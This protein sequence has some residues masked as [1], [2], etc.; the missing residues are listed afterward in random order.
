MVI[1]LLTDSNRPCRV[2]YHGDLPVPQPSRT[3]DGRGQCRGLA[4]RDFHL[5]SAE[6]PEVGRGATEL[7]SRIFK[8]KF[9]DSFK[10]WTELF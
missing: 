8:F 2:T 4:L 1:E 5:G 3:K 6:L 10:Q 9:L 7:E